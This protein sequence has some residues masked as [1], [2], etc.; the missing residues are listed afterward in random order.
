MKALFLSTAALFLICTAA[1][2]DADLQALKASYEAAVLR[3][4]APLVVKYETNLTELL[5]KRT[6]AG[7]LKAAVAIQEEIDRLKANGKSTAAT[8]GTSPSLFIGKTW[9]TATGTKFSFKKD[10]AGTREFGS[11]KTPLV[12][13]ELDKGKVEATGQYNQGAENRTWYFTFNSRSEAYYSDKKEELGT[14]LTLK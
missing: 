11:D 5:K 1:K 9:S 3:A 8:S 6:Q 14:K 2:G 7:D 4:T 10:G 13:R 12:W